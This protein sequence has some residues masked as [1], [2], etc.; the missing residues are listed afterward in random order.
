MCAKIIIRKWATPQSF[1]FY[2]FSLR[3]EKRKKLRKILVS[4]TFF[5]EAH[6][7]WEFPSALTTHEVQGI[8]TKKNDENNIFCYSVKLY[9]FFELISGYWWPV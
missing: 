4:L 7:F 1:P 6:I 2:V 5:P 8:C 3:L 9:E